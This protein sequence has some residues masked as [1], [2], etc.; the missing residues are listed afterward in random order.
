MEVRTRYQPGC[1]CRGTEHAEA[2]GEAGSEPGREEVRQGW[3]VVGVASVSGAALC[4]RCVAG[5]G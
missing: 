3:Q 1:S 5:Q 4:C 2:E